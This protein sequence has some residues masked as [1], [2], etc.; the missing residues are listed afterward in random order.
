M[1]NKIRNMLLVISLVIML[2]F[3]GCTSNYQFDDEEHDYSVEI[4]GRDMKLLS[5]QETADLW[6]IDSEILLQE[7]IQKFELKESYTANSVLEEIRDEY[8]FSPAM[9][10][11]IA[12]DIK[13]QGVI[14]E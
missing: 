6:G 1:K 5:V 12:E 8:K 4:E 3:V 2:V 10:K 7:I 9:I 13:Q 11:D 14:N